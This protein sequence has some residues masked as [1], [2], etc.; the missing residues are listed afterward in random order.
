MRPSAVVIH[1]NVLKDFCFCLFPGPEFHP[2]YKLY[3]KR[4]EETLCH[5]IIPAV[6]FFTHAADKL[7][8]RQ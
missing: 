7:L 3:L 6:A 2:V 5:R 4:V 8:L 1:F